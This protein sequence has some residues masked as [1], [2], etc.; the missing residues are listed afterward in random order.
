MRWKQWTLLQAWLD[1]CD[2]RDQNLEVTSLKLERKTNKAGAYQSIGLCPSAGGQHLGTFTEFGDYPTFPGSLR[3]LSG[4]CLCFQ[5]RSSPDE[6]TMCS[7][8]SFLQP[9]ARS[10]TGG[11]LQFLVTHKTKSF[12]RLSNWQSKTSKI[13]WTKGSLTSFLGSFWPYPTAGHPLSMSLASSQSMPGPVSAL[14]FPDNCWENLEERGRGH[15][16]LMP[17]TILEQ[18]GGLSITYLHHYWNISND[19]QPYIKMWPWWHLV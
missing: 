14:M 17:N 7:W 1:A 4:C 15:P 2:C 19:T 5:V 9:A 10:L 6:A 8:V 13:L 3:A 18:E 16:H 11:V 12:C